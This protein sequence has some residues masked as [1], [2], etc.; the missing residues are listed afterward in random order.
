MNINATLLYLLSKKRPSNS[1]EEP[2]ARALLGKTATYH[3]DDKGEFIA[4][5]VTIGNSRTL[6]SAHLD[7]VERNSGENTL[8]TYIDAKTGHTFVK[9]NNSVLGADDAAG[10]SI[11]VNMIDNG[12]A[13]H[14]HFYAMEEI[15]AVGS[16]W[17][18][19]NKP[20]LYENIDRAI[21]FDRKGTS[22][23]IAV[24][25]GGDCCSN[26]FALALSDALCAE[27][28]Y[29]E[30]SIGV[31]TDTA[32]MVGL[33]PECTNLSCGY[34]NEHSS[35][36]C[37]DLTFLESLSEAALRINWEALPT[38]RSAVIKKPKWYTDDWSVGYNSLHHSSYEFDN[39]TNDDV[40]AVLDL[41]LLNN[42]TISDLLLKIKYDDMLDLL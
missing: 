25:L 4:A 32:N 8:Q 7:T 39:Y 33:V 30:P 37:L 36:E 1:S 41:M 10:I 28:L 38:K 20:E 29:Y 34:Y 35:A 27:G 26:E 16:N 3:Y 42:V 21:A 17:L 6:F 40:D 22:D 18:V 24:Q 14:Y 2:T 9:A 31:F 19:S 11:M 23:V 12:I 15:G 5:T 13:G